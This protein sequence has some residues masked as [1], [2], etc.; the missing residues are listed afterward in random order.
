MNH[1][2]HPC[3]EIFRVKQGKQ[4]IK[5]VSH[6]IFHIYKYYFVK[7]VKKKYRHKIDNQMYYNMLR[8]LMDHKAVDCSHLDE[9]IF[10]L[11]VDNFRYNGLKEDI[12]TMLTEHVKF[13]DEFTKITKAVQNRCL[14]YSDETKKYYNEVK[15]HNYN[16]IAKYNDDN[17][18]LEYSCEICG[19][20]DIIVNKL[21]YEKLLRTVLEDRLDK[22][23]HKELVY[24]VLT[25][26]KLY[27]TNLETI[28]LSVDAVYYNRKIVDKIEL[29]VEM[30]SSAF[31]RHLCHIFSMYGDLEYYYGS[32]GPY[33]CYDENHE[34][35]ND[36]EYV[37]ANPPYDNNVMENMAKFIVRLLDKFNK[38]G[39]N[40]C[41]ITTIP[42]WRPNKDFPQAYTTYDILKDSSS[43][44]LEIIYDSDYDYYDYIKNTT[45]KIGS[46]GTII[47]VMKTD[48]FNIPLTKEDFINP[49]VDF[50]LW[51]E[52]KVYK[53][54]CIY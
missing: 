16:I 35:W 2:V 26:Y 7:K 9:P 14:Q 11:N 38:I 37:V 6:L 18:V 24:C 1:I 23:Y 50:N 4:F 49:D 30:F 46:T 10:P 52:S 41:F 12:N 51:K 43:K 32:L 39:K 40:I 44:Y 15:N 5:G 13:G 47:F 3:L 17:V 54:K 42:D 27:G 31:N 22:K 34:F 53:Q 33:N 25:R 48:N 20:K 36:K 28:S 21:T 29:Q 45:L 8:W 19:K